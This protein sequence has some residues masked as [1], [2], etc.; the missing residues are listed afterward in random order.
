MKTNNFQIKVGQREVDYRLFSPPD[1]SLSKSPILFLYFSRDQNDLDGMTRILS[2]YPDF[3]ATDCFLNAGHRVLTFDAPNHGERIDKY[4]SHIEGFC[5]AYMDGVDPFK[6]FIEDGKA[7][8]DHCIAS[9]YARPGRIV[10]GGVSRF[11]YL[12]FRLMA[13]DRRISAAAGY[14]PVTD[15][16]DIGFDKA[17]GKVDIDCLRLTNFV[18]QLAGRH[19]FIS[20]GNHDGIVNTS[21]CMRFFLALMEANKRAGFDDSY[22]DFYTTEDP[23][24]T[25]SGPW[26]TKSAEFLCKHVNFG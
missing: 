21:S 12:A 18:S 11:G 14:A 7:V 2:G 25:C 13:E 16:N 17:K 24:H 3:I 10:I 1:E 8:I 26:Y 19:I 22:V 6:I 5:N 15:W 4:G 9:G 23:G 20:V